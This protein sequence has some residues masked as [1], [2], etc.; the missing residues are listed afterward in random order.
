MYM[1]KR[2][3]YIYKSEGYIYKSE[4]ISIKV[5]LFMVF[6]YFQQF[7]MCILSCVFYHFVFWK[8]CKLYI[9]RFAIFFINVTGCLSMIKPLVYL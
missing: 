3:G 4:G 1:S 7:I 5:M 8:E 9:S 2:E 6:S